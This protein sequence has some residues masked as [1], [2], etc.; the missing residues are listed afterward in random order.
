MYVINEETF[1]KFLAYVSPVGE[2]LSEK[3][4]REVLNCKDT[5]IFPK[6]RKGTFYHAKGRKRHDK[7]PCFATQNM[8]F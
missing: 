5:R 6:M 8:A 4:L 2:Y 7:R 1:E 3:P